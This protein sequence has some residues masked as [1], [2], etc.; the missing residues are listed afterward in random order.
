MLSA[1]P[2]ATYPVLLALAKTAAGMPM[3]VIVWA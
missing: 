3:I 1:E 2:D